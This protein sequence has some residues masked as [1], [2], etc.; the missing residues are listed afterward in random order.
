MSSAR[1]G[2]WKHSDLKMEF[3]LRFDLPHAVLA[4]VFRGPRL[5]MFPKPCKYNPKYLKS[6]KEVTV[7]LGKELV[8]KAVPILGRTTQISPSPDVL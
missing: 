6:V 5:K 3:H 7:K 4:F 8:T 2:R 1:R